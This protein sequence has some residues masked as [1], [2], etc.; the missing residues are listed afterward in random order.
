MPLS[1][2]TGETTREQIEAW[3]AEGPSTGLS[4]SEADTL[5]AQMADLGTSSSGS[6]LDSAIVD[7]VEET[8]GGGLALR[9]HLPPVWIY[10]DRSDPDALPAIEAEP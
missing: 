8:G 4:D 10:L 2:P 7:A 9:V 6:L 5:I 1:D 3:R